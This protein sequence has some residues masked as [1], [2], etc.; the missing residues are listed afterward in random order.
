MIGFLIALGLRLWHLG[1]PATLVSDEVF[2]VN[3]AKHYVTEGTYFDPHPPLGKLQMGAA[4]SIFGFTPTTWRVINAVEGALII[5]LLWWIAWLLTR[6]KATAN[7]VMT[8]ALLEGSL[9]VESRLG[10][11]N[12]PYILYS[13]A[14]LAAV[15]RALEARRPRNW[16]ISAGLLFGLAI[17]VKW[18]ALL[19]VLPAMAVWFWPQLLG[20]QSANRR[21][22]ST[23]R[24]TGA[25]LFFLPILIYWGV[26]QI[27]IHW[28]GVRESFWHA[29]S[30][31]ANYHLAVPDHG[32]P[33]ASTWWTWPFLW[34]PF[35]YWSSVN[36]ARMEQLW[37]LGNPWIWWSGLI[38]GILAA[39]WARRERLIYGLLVFLAISWLPFAAITRVMYSYHA[40]LYGIWL[41]I[42]SGVVLGKLWDR[43]RGWV[44]AYL[45]I[46]T[47]AFLWF[48]PW[49]L[50][51]PLSESQQHLRAWLPNWRL[52]P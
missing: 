28:L 12:T 22:P 44:L 16:I 48:L 33:Q 19:I 50:N 20:R 29:Q 37:S 14:G 6:R 2:F 40:L 1:L 13:L 36:G 8:L 18:L 11:I 23:L 15:L 51:I 47:L 25:T 26:F 45:A 39:L 3:D 9:L 38:M 17:S 4:F 5:P 24:F 46:A 7:I 42:L 21:T 34:K 52:T 32:D 35:R 30:A 41:L 49:Y 10:L 31:M 43:H 27:H